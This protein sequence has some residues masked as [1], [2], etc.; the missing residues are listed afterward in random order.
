MSIRVQKSRDG[1][2][3]VDPSPHWYSDFP[4]YDAAVLICNYRKITREDSTGGAQG[5]DV[6]KTIDRDAEHRYGRDAA[7][8]FL[9]PMT[10]SAKVREPVN[11]GTLHLAV[12]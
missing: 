8:E 9:D 7:L 10:R 2:L 12:V 6:L 1:K 5:C 4:F 3:I 11:F